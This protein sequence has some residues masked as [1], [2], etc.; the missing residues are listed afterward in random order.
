MEIERQKQ[1]VRRFLSQCNEYADGKLAEYAERQE[2]IGSTGKSEDQ[3]AA[4]IERKIAQWQ[5]YK[6]FN[7]HALGELATDRLDHWFD[8]TDQSPPGNPG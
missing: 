4:G 8:D 1:I 2:S 7:E 5:S 3:E 6:A